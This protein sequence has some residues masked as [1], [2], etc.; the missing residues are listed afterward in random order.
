MKSK[1]ALNTNGF[2]K[3]AFMVSL[4]FFAGNSWASSEEAEHDHEDTEHS[5]AEGDHDT[6]TEDAHGEEGGF[7]AGE[8][9]LHHIADSHEWHV[10][11]LESGPVSIPLPIIVYHSEKGLSF[12]L[13]SKFEHGHTDHNGY[14]LVHDEIMIVAEDGTI[15]EEASAG[16]ID[17]SITK[18]AF[19]MILSC[20]F[21]VWIFLS[22]AKAYK[23]REGQ[24]PKGLQSLLEPVIL[25][26]R[27][28]IAKSSIDEKKYERYMPFLL[29]LFFFILIINVM[30][31]IPIPGLGGANVTGNVAIPVVLALFVFVI[32]N[33]SGNKHYWGHIF[34]MPGVPKLVLLILTPIE[35]MQI[36]IR[37]V[38]LVIR[39]FANIMAG[40]IVMLVFFSLIFIAGDGCQEAGGFSTAVPSI[41]FTIFLT[42]LELLVAAI[43]AYVFTLLAAIYIG[44]AVA[45]PNH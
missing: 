27:D 7:N 39:L 15:D 8:M 23:K 30:G 42:F 26:V 36:F 29:T 44:M 2:A 3:L 21:L 12:F 11:D 38:V 16:I 5:V 32:V 17:L 40:H 34:A 24:A 13:S 45:E 4:A 33:V 20:I 18:N 25:F 6:H 31:L 1:I 43:Q 28:N 37:P 35:F 14:R 9:I 41:A 19:M 10:M 22:V